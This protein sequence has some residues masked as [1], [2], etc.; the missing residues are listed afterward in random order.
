MKFEGWQIKDEGGGDV[1][2][3]ILKG[4]GVFVMDRLMDERTNEW[5]FVNV[6]L[7][8]QLKNYET[9]RIL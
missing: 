6:E 2:K 8:L 7:L 1:E 9:L 3:L 4:W 5:T